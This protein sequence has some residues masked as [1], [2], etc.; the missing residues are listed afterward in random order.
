MKSGGSQPWKGQPDTKAVIKRVEWCFAAG[1]KAPIEPAACVAEVVP[2][3][4]AKIRLAPALASR[5]RLR[6][7]ATAGIRSAG[8]RLET[9]RC[10]ETPSAVTGCGTVVQSQCKK[11]HSDGDFGS[12]L[13][14]S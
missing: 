6:R 9:S 1:R 5:S 3:S 13:Q 10:V 12:P 4:L 7:T 11:L 2:L 8:R 14:L